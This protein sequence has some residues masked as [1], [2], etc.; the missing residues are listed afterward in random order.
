MFSNT[1][2]KFPGIRSCSFATLT[3]LFN[4]TSPTI[5]LSG[6]SVRRPAYALFLLTS[7]LPNSRC[8]GLT[9][10][11]LHNLYTLFISSYF[12]FLFLLVVEVLFIILSW[13]ARCV[14]VRYWCSYIIC[15]SLWCWEVLINYIRNQWVRKWANT[16]FL[17]EYNLKISIHF[18]TNFNNHVYKY[19]EWRIL[20]TGSKIPVY[21][22]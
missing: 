20:F 12:G 19:Y 6:R 8:P 21:K 14:L 10:S 16:N 17:F 18:D 9:W 2:P 7:G 22:I 11:L 1:C 13:Q 3:F 4:R 15:C 5:A